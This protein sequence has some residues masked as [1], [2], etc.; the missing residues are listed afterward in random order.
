MTPVTKAHSLTR[1]VAK[2]DRVIALATASSSALTRWRLILF[3]VG[4]I[5]TVALYKMGWY[6]SGNGTLAAFVGLFLIVAGY[7]NRLESRLHRL[8]LWKQ[9]KLVHLA[10]LRLDWHHIPAR[11]SSAPEHHPYAK[12]LDLVASARHHRLLARTDAAGGV[13]S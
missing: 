9:I 5:C 2:L 7:H 4:A 6:Q 12:D 10:R 13:A 1:L 11:P 8:R 3:I